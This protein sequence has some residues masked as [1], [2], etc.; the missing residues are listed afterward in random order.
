MAAA[1]HCEYCYK[2]NIFDYFPS[3][4]LKNSHIF[5]IWDNS[6]PRKWEQRYSFC[7]ILNFQFP[8]NG[9]TYSAMTMT[10]AASI[11]SLI[12]KNIFSF[13]LCLHQTRKGGQVQYIIEPLS[14]TWTIDP[15]S[16]FLMKLIVAIKTI[17][18]IGNASQKANSEKSSA[19]SWFSWSSASLNTQKYTWGEGV[20]MVDHL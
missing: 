11:Y 5:L 18:I 8:F 20:V 9:L 17:I 3:K 4:N 1:I 14:S 13:C 19:C 2:K 15:L 10:F 12:N 16:F 6:R 7:Q